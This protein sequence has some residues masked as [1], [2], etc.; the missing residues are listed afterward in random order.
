[1]AIKKPFVVGLTGGVATGKSTALGIFKECGI[2]VISCDAI[3]RKLTQS[4]GPI[5]GAIRN[6]FGKDCFTKTG[7]LRR[8]KLLAAIADSRKARFALGRIMHP[9][10]KKELVARI[11][12]MRHKRAVVAEIPLLFEEKME[13]LVNETVVI[14]CSLKTQITRLRSRGRISEKQ[15]GKILAMQYPLSY[16]EKRA[17]YVISNDGTIRSLAGQIKKYLNLLDKKLAIN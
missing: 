16:K 3:A 2:N 11:K 13:R 7:K 14:T 10:I 17:D 6:K 9:Q 12:E 8:K 1:M 5:A 4:P 15:C